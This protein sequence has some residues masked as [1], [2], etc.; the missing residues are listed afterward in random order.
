MIHIRSSV[1]LAVPPT[2]LFE[3]LCDPARKASLNPKITVL[4]ATLA[5]PGPVGVGSEFFYS[6]KIGAGSAAFRCRVT[7][8]E[9]NRL[10][11]VVSDTARPFRVRHAIEPTVN[12]CRLV[13][14]EWVE[15]GPAQAPRATR[16]QN[17]FRFMNIFNRALD[18]A[19]PTAHDLDIEANQRLSHEMQ[20]DLAVWLANIKTHLETGSAHSDKTD[21]DSALAHLESALLA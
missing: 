20:N 2:T 19:L 4:N 21:T 1:E 6:L 14:D 7:A 16:E 8:F 18:H 15:A 17:A 11:E 10:I 13:H 5:T 12:G 9:A 3:L